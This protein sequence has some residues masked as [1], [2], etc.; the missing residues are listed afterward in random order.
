MRVFTVSSKSN[1]QLNMCSYF[2]KAPLVKIF[3][4]FQIVVYL[5]VFRL[6]FTLIYQIHTRYYPL[7]KC[8][9]NRPGETRICSVKGIFALF[10]YILTFGYRDRHDRL[11]G[12]EAILHRCQRNKKITVNDHVAGKH[13]IYN[14]SRQPEKKIL[15]CQIRHQVCFFFVSF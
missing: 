9:F 11:N 13:R 8:H 1:D 6:F 10:F 15:K 2:W 3:L 14:R 5:V 7:T 12:E 4:Q